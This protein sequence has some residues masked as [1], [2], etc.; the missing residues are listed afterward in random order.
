MDKKSNNR[1]KYFGIIPLS[2][3]AYM[4]LQTVIYDGKNEVLNEF[5]PTFYFIITVIIEAVLLYNYF[6]YDRHRMNI[7]GKAA[8]FIML[9]ILTYIVII[10]ILH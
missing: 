7:F 9:A 3:L 2:T 6:R 4:I 5:A 1:Y 10:K 8:F